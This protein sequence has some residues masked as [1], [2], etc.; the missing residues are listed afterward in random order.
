[1]SDALWDLAASR[2][3]KTVMILV[4][5]LACFG[6]GPA[7][8]QT[9]Q[10]ADEELL[11]LTGS[12]PALAADSRGGFVT[13]WTDTEAGNEGLGIRGCLLAPKKGSCGPHFAVNTTAIGDQIRPSVTADDPGRFVVAWQG[14]AEPGTGIFGQ[15]FGAGGV[16]LGSELLL[17]GTGSGVP[18]WPKVA[19]GEG[20]DFI[21]AWQ[22]DQDNRIEVARFSAKGK[23]LG[24]PFPMD[25]EGETNNGAMVARYPSGFTVGWHEF[26]DQSGGRSGSSFA[27]VA[28]FDL[29]GRPVGKIERLGG[30][31]GYGIDALVGSRSGALAVFASSDGHSAQRFE[32][33]GEAKGVRF[34]IA[35]QPQCTTSDG[36]CES[37]A[38][39][40]MDT[41]GRFVVIWEVAEGATFNLFAQLFTPGGKARTERIAVN[42][43][44]STGF[45]SPAVALADD[46]G[47]MVAWVRSDTQNPERT[48]LFLRRM[49][50]Q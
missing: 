48:G 28:S 32:A 11:S 21:A 29:S 42:A 37:V 9:P 43:T 4:A 19:M 6:M 36:P 49:R 1:M 38:A 24:S 13:V 40:D 7:A 45:E 8:A 33:A 35:D 5:A 26:F 14:P 10:S 34:P 50:L 23:P 47:V 25:A 46:G 22:N 27:A 20:G 44:P 12:Q 3:H 41:R 2:R 30:S 18:A 16:K 39:V 31:Q 17:S 15:R